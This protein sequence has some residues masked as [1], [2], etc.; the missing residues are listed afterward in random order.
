MLT[1][2]AALEKERA[3]AAEAQ[4][5]AAAELERLQSKISGQGKEIADNARQLLSLKEVETAARE[6]KDAELASMQQQLA[7]R[8][9]QLRGAT[10][11]LEA[12][13]A[14]FAGQQRVLAAQ[15]E[16]AESAGLRKA[17]LEAEVSRL[18][19]LAVL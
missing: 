6:A 9:E 3:A 12:K 10:A 8:T 7:E 5:R 19:G 17:E 4:A 2:I 18:S 11:A 14:E 13:E 15:V 16:R 1:K